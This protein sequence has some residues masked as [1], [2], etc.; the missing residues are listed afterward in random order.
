MPFIQRYSD[1]KK[2]AIVFTGNTLGLSKASNSNS[3]GLEGS[4]GAFTS[5][6][7]SLQVGN[8]PPGTTL[9][10]AQNGSA[11]QLTLPPDSDILYA[12]L[13]WGGLYQSTVNNISNLINNPVTFTT[14]ASV[15]TVIPDPVTAQNF[16]ITVDNVTVGFYTRSANVTALLQAA[17]NGTYSLQGVPALIEAIDSR[18]SQTNHAGW[19]L[20]VA[21]ENA[22]ITLRNLTLWCGGAVVSPSTGTTT[23][24]VSDFLTP[25]V[26]PIT[27]KIFVSGQEGD[28]VLSGDQMLFGETTAT[29]MPLSGPNNPQG[30][31]F[32]SQINDS[33]GFLDTTGT[34]GS[35]NANAAAGTNT[36]AC[37]QGWD[38]T[39]VD[40]SA[41]LNAGQNS[42]A[43]RFTS[44]GDLYVPNA[45]GILIDS[46]GANLTIE[47]SAAVTYAAVGQD[48]PYS[49]K[50]TNTG[51]V[52]ALNATVSDML[53]PGMT[54]TAGSIT[55]D[56]APYAG[57]LPVVIPQIDAGA[58]VT[59][60]FS[61]SAAALPNPNPVFNIA[62][63][64]FQ[65]YP[66]TGYLADSF[67][68]SNPVAVYIIDMQTQIVKSVDKEFAV[69]GDILTYTST[70]TNTGSVPVSSIFFKDA[71][72][73]GTEFVSGSVYIDGINYPAYNPQD[74]F[75]AG[76]LTP[77]ESLII[78]FQTTIN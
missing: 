9:D 67:S 8:F 33:D 57:A 65:F 14:P 18:T 17:G 2:G 60:G 5:L 52:P 6:D 27:G 58:D 51:S 48:I 37:L 43:I 30:N 36:L 72:P 39:A 1:V 40:I 77:Q 21:Y 73:A 35:R 42:A 24:T 44:S 76:S 32:A 74:G 71:I 38:I 50:I 66:F 16:L 78:T 75:A 61:A 64:N 63:V 70:V 15:Q 20:A 23:V 4:I 11:A 45:L 22:D 34:F 56:G 47:K 3:P 25:D 26:L 12:E 54:L 46:K 68:E 59:V 29:L 53:P 19:T 55:I 69:S 13:I 62:R 41:Q 7:V 31:F 28:A 10:Y 49:L